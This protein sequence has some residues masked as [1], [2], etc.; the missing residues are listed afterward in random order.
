MAARSTAL[1]APGATRVAFF[2]TA[3]GLVIG[4]MFVVYAL[5]WQRH[6]WPAHHPWPAISMAGFVWSAYVGAFSRRAQVAG[7]GA[8]VVLGIAGMALW[9]SATI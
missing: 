9:V 3:A 8:A 1:P 6:E 2:S 7:F 5:A 4:A